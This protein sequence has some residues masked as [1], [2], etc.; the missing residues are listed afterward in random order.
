VGAEDMRT[1]DRV[2][3]E[4]PIIVTAADATGREFIETTK[5]LV[6][7]RRGAKIISRQALVPQ[8]R[9][10][11]R[12][13]KTGL[14]TDGIV[15]GLIAREEE[16]CYYGIAFPHPETN[17]WG[18]DFPLLTGAENPAA[19]VFLE[20]TRC[21]SQEVTHLDV[22]ELEVLMANERLSR[23]CRRCGGAA[24]WTQPVRGEAPFPTSQ[25]A[26]GPHRCIHERKA[27]RVNLEVDVCIRHPVHGEEVVPTVNVSQGGFRFVSCNDYAVG[28]LIEAALPYV[29]G[30]ANIF[31]PGRIVYRAEQG[32]EGTIAY[33]VAY[34]P[35]RIASSLT[36]MRISRLK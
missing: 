6:L 32:A 14:E 23:S 27:P 21:H 19:R 31:S 20:C 1:S 9:L 8:Q 33:G 13:A 24:L 3:L 29:F 25:V 28:A 15:V 36:G 4:L 17:L 12:C 30:A 22:F 10:R 16:G 18:I 2:Y 34:L 11:I 35:S 7:S 26:P 5:T